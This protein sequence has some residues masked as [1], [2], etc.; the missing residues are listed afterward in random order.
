LLL[1]S[2]FSIVLLAKMVLNARLYHYGFYLAMPAT[3][4]FAALALWQVPAFLGQGPW[5]AVTFR[6]A[7]L[8]ALAVGVIAHVG[9]ALQ[10]CADKNVVVG[11]GG[12]AMVAFSPDRGPS[13]IAAVRAL[14]FIESSMPAEATFVVLPEGVMLNYLSRRPNPTPYINFMIVEMLAFG[15]QTMLASFKEHKPDYFVLVHKDS[16]EHGLAPFGVEPRFGKAIMDWVNAEY[17][18]VALFGKEPLRNPRDF[19]IKIMKRRPAIGTTDE[20][21]RAGHSSM[22][23]AQ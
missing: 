8:A 3:M 23:G 21:G 19:G 17:Q 12:D 22:G 6:S 7:A 11:K 9:L 4:A 16:S 14:E 20:S 18:P 5:R 15:E 2:T 13:G 10:V 1:W